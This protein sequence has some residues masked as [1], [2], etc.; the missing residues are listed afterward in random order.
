[1][2]DSSF[3]AAVAEAGDLLGIDI[4]NPLAS[5][6]GIHDSAT[7]ELVIQPDTVPRFEF[8][9][10]RRISDYP[11]EQGAFASY[12]KVATPYEIR[13]TMVCSGGLVRQAESFIQSALGIDSGFM[14]K[15]NF[16]DRL[17]EML[18]TTKIF[19][20]VTPDITYFGA[21]LEHY[22]YKR[23]TRDGATMLKV[24][25]W[26]REVR[27]TA[28]ATYSDGGPVNSNSPSAADPVS[29]G[30]VHPGDSVTVSFPD[31]SPIQ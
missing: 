15:S 2:A 14:Q 30:T 7:G 19:S 5:D 20:I 8:R 21:N 23:E 11:V 17:D 18:N 4:L 12:N 28:S 27:V 3:L 29:L 1:M 16:I 25:A 13:M 24:E 9:G 6:W 26:F 10:D 31:K 22:D